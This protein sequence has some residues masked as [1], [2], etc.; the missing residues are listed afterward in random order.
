MSHT[1]AIPR[2]AAQAI[3]R[4]ASRPG[5][6][7]AHSTSTKAPA[8]IQRSALTQRAAFSVAASRF[9]PEVI[10]EAEVPVSIYSPDAKGVASPNSDHF[11]IPVRHTRQV[12]EPV[13]NSETEV[14]APLSEKLYSRLP[15]TM[16][17]MTVMGKVI[18]V[19][20]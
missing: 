5:T 16:Q 1:T 18:I 15:A 13:N 11:S 8:F 3:L 20:G 14:V 9:K 4:H 10:K 12:Q 7:V 2:L 19:T 6:R 17:K